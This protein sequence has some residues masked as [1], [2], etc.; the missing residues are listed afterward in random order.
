MPA[1]ADLEK[2]KFN[3]QGEIKVAGDFAVAG[4]TDYST[5]DIT[6]LGS[7]TSLSEW[8]SAYHDGQLTYKYVADWEGTQ[9]KIVYLTHP[10]LGDNYKCL[11]LFYI[12]STQNST[13]VVQS[14]NASVVDWTFDDDVQGALTLTLGTITS[15]ASNAPT[16]T[17]VCTVTIANTGS[18]SNTLSLSGTNAAKYRFNNTTQSQTGSTLTNVLTTDTVV[19]ETVPA[20]FTDGA[21]YSHSITVTLTESNFNNTA[22]QNFSTSGTLIAGFQNTKYVGTNVSNTGVNLGI[23]Q[24]EMDPAGLGNYSSSDV[25]QWTISF[26]AKTANASDTAQKGVAVRTFG[27]STSNNYEATDIQL[28]GT[29]ILMGGTRTATHW[30][31]ATIAGGTTSWRHYVVRYSTGASYLYKLCDIFVDGVQQGNATSVYV[32]FWLDMWAPTTNK[33]IAVCGRYNSTSSNYAWG[34]QGTGTSYDIE[35]YVDELS[36]WNTALTSTQITSLYNSGSPGDLDGESNLVR[37]FRFGDHASDTGT[38]M[39]DSQDTNDTLTGSSDYR[40]SY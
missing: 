16:G 37:W 27:Q 17:D 32:N 34:S 36:F 39:V 12:Y 35:L 23:Y 15:P 6:A 5:S 31:G 10:S 9:E 24:G 18:G 7:S 33:T 14:I 8:V 29:Q 3:A 21:A 4:Q 26:W 20:S 22:T 38:T 2:D 1:L 28:S 13:S 25:A 11:R 30:K 19:I 40:Q